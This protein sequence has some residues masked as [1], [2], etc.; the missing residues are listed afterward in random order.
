VPTLSLSL[1]PSLNVDAMLEIEA[2]IF[3]AIRNRPRSQSHWSWH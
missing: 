1:A 2:V 3:V